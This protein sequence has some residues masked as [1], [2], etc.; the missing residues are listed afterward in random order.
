MFRNKS[1]SESGSGIFSMR[2][3]SMI[4]TT[5]ITRNLARRSSWEQKNSFLPLSL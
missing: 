4:M 1:L 2:H 3:I 5:A